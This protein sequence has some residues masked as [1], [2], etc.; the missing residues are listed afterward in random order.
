MSL[1]RKT[2]EYYIG[3]SSPLLIN[4]PFI[5]LYWHMRRLPTEFSEPCCVKCIRHFLT[6]KYQSSGSEWNIVLASPGCPR[7]FSVLANKG[8]RAIR[9]TPRE[10]MNVH[11]PNFL[12]FPLVWRKDGKRADVIRRVTYVVIATS[13][14]GALRN[15]TPEIR[16][17]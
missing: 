8:I 12:F 3:N 4:P 6:W 2:T 1:Q 14:I 11:W 16:I 5:L 9:A 13:Y 10:F 7:Q 15:E 17:F